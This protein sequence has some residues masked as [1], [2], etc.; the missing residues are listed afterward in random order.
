MDPRLERILR[1]LPGWEGSAAAATPLSGGITNRNYRVEIRGE[2]YVLRISGENTRLLGID[3][4]NEHAAA[5]TAANLGVAPEVVLFLERE[6]ALLTRFVSG[7]PVTPESAAGPETL[8]RIVES[9]RRYHQGPP[10]PGLFSPF[11]TVRAYHLEAENRGV[12]FPRGFREPLEAMELMER[13]LGPPGTLVPCHND[14]LAGNFIDDGRKVWILDWEY[15]GMGDPFFDLGNFA[16]NQKLDEEGCRRLL[17]EYA[18]RSERRELARL[19]LQRLASDL[20]EAW[21][22]FLQAGVSRLE[23]DFLGYGTRHLERFLEERKRP[24]FARWIEE[25]R[26]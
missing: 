6:G 11:E 12:K 16:A 14:L 7:K 19:H 26:A 20:R 13:A 21:W 18:G 1:Q 4:R 15:A 2:P 9:I 22:G 8:P 3:R 17:G 23:F 24:T 5:S 25:A 10:F